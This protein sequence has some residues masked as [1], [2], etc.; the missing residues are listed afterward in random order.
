M[1]FDETGQRAFSDEIEL[2]VEEI[3]KERHYES[4]LNDDG[5]KFW[6]YYD[7]TV[8]SYGLANF[9][10]GYQE[11]LNEVMSTPDR[12]S[13]AACMA[14]QLRSKP[15]WQSAISGLASQYTALQSA[16]GMSDAL[17]TDLSTMDALEE[18]IF[19]SRVNNN[20]ILRRIL[21]LRQQDDIRPLPKD[22]KG[23]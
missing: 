19:F 11:F 7:Q 21:M 10:K 9:K 6:D 14:M 15:F 13:Y 8:I 23:K 1:Y 2:L 20:I 22:P 17:D 4:L 3:A 5:T 18:L 16:V 12:A